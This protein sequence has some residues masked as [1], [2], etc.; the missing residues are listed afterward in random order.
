MQRTEIKRTCLLFLLVVFKEHCSRG[1][2][3]PVLDLFVLVRRVFPRN[4][5]SLP[6]GSGAPNNGIFS[7]MPSG[8]VSDLT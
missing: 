7:L 3:F 5:Q 2:W 8:R 1:K 6:V 4:N